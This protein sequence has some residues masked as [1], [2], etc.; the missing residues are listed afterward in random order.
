MYNLVNKNGIA[1]APTKVY[2]KGKEIYTFIGKEEGY[3]KLTD[4]GRVPCSFHPM[5]L[6]KNLF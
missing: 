2:E 3:L 5:I 6:K 4:I 1:F